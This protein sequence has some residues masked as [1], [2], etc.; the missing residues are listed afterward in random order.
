MTK[1]ADLVGQRF[2]RLVAVWRTGVK[3]GN[4]VWSCRCDCGNETEVMGCSLKSGHTRSCGCYNRDVLSDRATHRMTGTPTYAAWIDMKT[5]CGNE[6]I[7]GYHSY[8]G[9]GIKV[10]DTW[11][12][13]EN[14]LADMGERPAGLSLDRIDNNGDYAPDN[15]RWATKNQQARNKRNNRLLSFKGETRCLSEWAEIQGIKITTLFQRL[16]A[17]G[18]ST[19]RALSTRTRGEV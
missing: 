1:M 18:W 4:A 9:R 13:F 2:G 14:F 17:Y 12:S 7:K 11:E 16:Y 15:C 3:D 8:G 19:E 10:C 5:R 6:K